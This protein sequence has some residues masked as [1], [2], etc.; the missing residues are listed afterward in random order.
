MRSLRTRIVALVAGFGLAMGAALAVIMYQA[1]SGYHSEA[2]YERASRF[3]GQIATM[4]P[5]LWRAYESDPEGFARR[6]REF[7][8]YS[9][10]IGLYLLDNDGRVLVRSDRRPEDRAADRIDISPVARSLARDAREPVRGEDP[11]TPGTTRLV[12][13]LPVVEDGVRR[14]W[15]YVVPCKWVDEPGDR[16]YLDFALRT[17]GRVGLL[18]LAIGVLLTLATVIMIT[19]PLTRLTRVADRI[20]KSGFEAEITECDF[21]T[22]GRHD[23]IGRLSCTL[24]EMFER[25]K[26]EIQRVKRTDAAR[27]EM[28]ASVSHDLRTPLT[29]LLGQLETIRIK[30]DVLDAEAIERLQD[31]ALQN[32]QYL[33]T[34]TE[35]LAELAKL[36]SPEFRVQ[37]EPLQIGELTDDVVQR[38]ATRAEGRGIQLVVD[39]PDGLPLAPVDAALL[40]RAL[41]NL[42]DNALRVTPEGGRVAVEVSRT[43]TGMRVAVTDS[44]PGVALEEQESVFELFY[45]TSKHRESRGSSGLGLAIVRRV[46]ELHGGRAGLRSRP[47]EGATFFIELPAAA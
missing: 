36:D 34:L 2:D 16:T 8:Q 20:T 10:D 27:R 29:A 25:L 26:I 35:A 24:R 22:C 21:R 37:A 30:R 43:S 39:Y 45:Q 18:T 46:A 28:I 23:E 17:A 9:P 7:N 5:D 19:R 31:R 3:A 11:G 14:G 12:A 1:I 41:S 40:D 47:G 44:G 13:A 32:A 6:F 42:L 4:H 15:L 38:F 33:R